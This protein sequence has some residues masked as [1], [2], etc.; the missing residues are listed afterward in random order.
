MSEIF[1]Y[2][3][4]KEV[5][6][7]IKFPNLFSIENKIGEFQEKI[8]SRFP[9]SKLVLQRHL[10]FGTKGMPA[11]KDSDEELNPA[12]V[13]KIWTF[14]SKEEIEVRVKTTSVNI[15]SKKHKTYNNPNEQQRFK[16]TIE[17]VIGNFLSTIN[18]P[19]VNRIGL[20][21]IDECPLPTSDNETLSR[22]YNSSFPSSRF[23]M[24]DVSESYLFINCVRKNHRLIYQESKVKTLEGK[25]AIILDFDGFE[26]NVAAKDYLQI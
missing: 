23:S 15:I 13:T 19:L 7:E 16:D 14:L 22:L 6:F 4:I 11:N 10:L 5:A 24:K 9:D 3:T 26:T 18:V 12:A 1:A 25:D 8:I 21:Y 17:F 20:R 2:P